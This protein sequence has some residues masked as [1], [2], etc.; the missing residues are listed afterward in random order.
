MSHSI[1]A[2]ARKPRTAQRIGDQARS[3]RRRY[4]TTLALL[5]TGMVALVGLALMVG[6]ISV[7]PADVVHALAG[8]PLAPNRFIVVG[9]RLPR[10]LGAMLAGA[11][12]GL[13][14]AI[15]QSF[16]RNPLASPDIIGVTGGASV[17]AVFSIMILGLSGPVV[18]LYALLGGLSCAALVHAI[19]NNGGIDRYRYVLTGIG[20][21]VF[22]TGIVSF[23]MISG[24]IISA[25]QA[26]VWL[27]GS[28]NGFSWAKLHL[29]FLCAAVILPF[30]VALSRS[31]SLLEMGDD[32]AT[33]LGSRIRLIR[34]AAIFVGSA[35]AATA[36]AAVGPVA[37]V[38]LMA[39]PLSHLFLP[40]RTAFV[41]AAMTGA[42]LLA[43][44]DIVAQNM[45]GLP[46]LPVGAVTGLIG[47]PYF[48]WRLLSAQRGA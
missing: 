31:L 14:G 38:A 27:T 7:A 37:F 44:A 5:L 35:L 48:I 21:S 1:A 2:P 34:L 33:G 20:V 36:T 46:Q 6:D 47:A 3:R 17:A 9:L 13:S 19:A 23:L 43:G 12:F 15:F 45:P 32:V 18:T 29:L 22:L 26:L 25:Q 28:L 16:L 10:V 8:D 39:A 41:P 42:G 11:C 30:G 40:G 4:S 24:E